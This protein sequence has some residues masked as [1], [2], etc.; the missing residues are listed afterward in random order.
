MCRTPK[1][2]LIALCDF[3]KNKELINDLIANCKLKNG[4]FTVFW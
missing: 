4:K 3:Q 2:K 1:L